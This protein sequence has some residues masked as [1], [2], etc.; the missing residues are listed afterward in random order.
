MTDLTTVAWLMPEI[1]LVVMAAYIFICGTFRQWQNRQTLTFVALAS[2]GVSAFAL[3]K[4]WHTYVDL[5]NAGNASL[6][7]VTG[8][9][10]IDH[11]AHLSR[12]FAL[13]VG[14]LLILVGSGNIHQRLSAEYLGTILLT[15]VGLM[16]IGSASELV[17]LFLGLELISIP[18]YVLLFLGRRDRSSA[19]ATVKY[20][21]LNLLASAILLYGFSFLYGILG[22]TSLTPTDAP[23]DVGHLAEIAFVLIFAGLGFKIAVVP[24]HFYAPDV[25][26]GTTNANAGLLAVVPKIAGIVAL[27]RLAPV[28]LPLVT[29]FAWQLTIAISLLT[30]TLGNVCALWQNDVRRLMA[31]SSIAH[32]GYLLIGLAA[33]FAAAATQLDPEVADF[34]A[35]GFAASLFYLGVYAFGTIATFA[36]LTYLSS[37]QRELSRIDDLAGLVRTQPLAAAIMGVAMFSLAGIPPLAGFWGKFTLFNSAISVATQTTDDQQTK[38]FAVLAIV[39]ALNAAVAAAYYLR[40]IGVMFFRPPKTED[41]APRA[42]LGALT[43]ACVSGVMLVML[44][45]MP[46]GSILMA[47]QADQ[48]IHA[49]ITETQFMRDDG[50]GADR[51][52]KVGQRSEPAR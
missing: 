2:L 4:Q 24:F 7:G 21:F 19:E 46:G 38:W 29:Q 33:G 10:A 32:A 42:G 49:R 25:Y 1:S 44:G 22:T 35:G 20:F 48:S 23:Q 14:A 36:V 47:E 6:L 17:F 8:P 28:L 26:Q 43:A 18:T 16:L 37:D 27:L 45:V 40:I 13:A 52:E 3:F 41:A 51:P 5:M 31:Y 9:L 39:G 34:A 15:V 12:W 50:S 30:M 11:L